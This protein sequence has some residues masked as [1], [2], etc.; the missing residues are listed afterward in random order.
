MKLGFK[1][2]LMHECWTIPTA[3]MT[4]NRSQKYTNTMVGKHGIQNIQSCGC[5]VVALGVVVSQYFSRPGKRTSP[6]LFMDKWF[7]QVC[8]NV[9]FYLPPVPRYPKSLVPSQSMQPQPLRAYKLG[10]TASH[11]V[12]SP[13]PRV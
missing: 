12:P 6:L 5:C 3:N 13:K 4:H 2:I 8:L 1:C 7:F 10:L 11:G 9:D